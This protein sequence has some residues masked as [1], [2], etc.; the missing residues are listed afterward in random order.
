MKQNVNI[1][2]YADTYNKIMNVV[3]KLS[4]GGKVLALLNDARRIFKDDILPKRVIVLKWDKNSL[5]NDW[6][7]DGGPTLLGY[8]N[9][10]A[11]SG[12][13]GFAYA[14][15]DFSNNSDTVNSSGGV[16]ENLFAIEKKIVGVGA[17][18]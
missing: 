8:L 2:I 18:E 12:D 9:Y 15:I 10:F 3:G 5:A 4:D 7:N 6:D 14:K 13:D 1:I 17:D 16:F 11:N